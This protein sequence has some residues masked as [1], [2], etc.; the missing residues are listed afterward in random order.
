MSN[1]FHNPYLSPT[2][3]DSFAQNNALGIPP[4][5][6]KKIEA[7]IKDARQF[8][9]AILLSFLCSIIGFLLIGPWYV[10]RLVQ[11]SRLSGKYPALMTPNPPHGTLEQRFQSSRWKLIVGLVAGLMFFILIGLLMLASIGA[12]LQVAPPG[13]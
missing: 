3:T 7:V 13:N 1:D 4:A 8:W 9:L 6:L 2:T 10:I 5:D 11:W 12:S